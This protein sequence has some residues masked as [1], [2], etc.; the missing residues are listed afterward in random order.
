MV[1]GRETKRRQAI[2]F[3]PVM[4]NIAKTIERTALL[5]FLLCFADGRDHSETK[6]RFFVYGYQNRYE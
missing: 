5:Q 1:N 6:T 2:H 4:D 3:L